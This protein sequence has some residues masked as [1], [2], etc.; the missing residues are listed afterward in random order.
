MIKLLTNVTTTIQQD[1]SR[2]QK[3]DATSINAKNSTHFEVK[4]STYLDGH[5][6]YKGDQIRIE[7]VSHQDLKACG[8]I[9]KTHLN[10]D[11][12]TISFY[13]LDSTILNT[14]NYDFLEEVCHQF[15]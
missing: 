11:P 15:H 7:Q 14:F 5:Y 9:L 3:V 4:K 8:E 12:L 1:T 2:F 10:K 13:H 6:L